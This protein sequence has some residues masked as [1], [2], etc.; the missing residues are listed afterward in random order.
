MYKILVLDDSKTIN[1]LIYSIFK[2]D[3]ECYRAFNIKEAREI[4]E[5]H[6]VDYIMLDINLPDGN[7]YDLVEELQSKNIKIFV[8]T[9]EDDKQFIEMNYQKGIIEYIIKDKA[10]LHKAKHIPK[11][12]LRL[13]ENRTKT[14]LII[15]DSMFIRMQ[16]KKLFENRYYNVIAVEDTKEALVEL[17]KQQID[18]IL[19]DIELKEENGI[20]FLSKN[21]AMIVDDK[22]IPVMIVSG[23]IDELITKLSIKAGA[24]D[25]LKK[26]YITEEIILKVDSWIDYNRLDNQVR[27]LQE[28]YKNISKQKESFQILLDAAMEMIFIH[29]KDLNIIDANKTAYKSLGFDE[30]DDLLYKNLLDFIDE[31]EHKKILAQIQKQDELE[32][33]VE[34]KNSVDATIVTLCKTKSSIIDLENIYITTMLDITT[35]KQK[36]TQLLHQSR[37]AQMG[38]MISMIAHQWRQPLNTISSYNDSIKLKT[39]LD[40]IDNET[41]MDITKKIST[42][43]HFLSSTIDDFRNFF[44]PDKEMSKTT[45]NKITNDVLEIIEF[46][47]TNNHITCNIELNSH[48]QFMSFENE[49]KQVVINLIKNAQ[50]ALIEKNIEEPY[51]EIK[52]YDDDKNMIFQIKDN[53]GGIEQHIIEKIFKPYFSTKSEKEGTGLGLY[54]SKTIVEKHCMGQLLVEN[55]CDGV[56]FKIVLKMDKTNEN[57]S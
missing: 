35:L 7:G 1:N 3:F 6:K 34:I 30:K 17:N 15:D 41:I 12:I 37:L 55:T 16:L 11:T 49:L 54:M 48:T 51:I 20:D 28:S 18:L 2:K 21:K 19:L 32:H 8:L 26:P 57:L 10:F 27:E 24:V 38:E 5:T 43:V 40:K 23:F 56:I 42:Q 9:T 47:L 13:E 4:L 25:V 46:S 14:I 50:D 33:E 22:K 29:D 44:K 39:I 31:K 52:T 53:G 36:E 45:L